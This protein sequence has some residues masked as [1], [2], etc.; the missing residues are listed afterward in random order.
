LKRRKKKIEI[1]GCDK[2]K[3]IKIRIFDKRAL[4]PIFATLLLAAIVITFGTVAYYYAS[5]VTTN[6]TNS[7]VS[8]VADSKVAISE[9]V[10]FENVVFTQNPANI[11]A[12]LINCGSLNLQLSTL[13]IYNSNQQVVGFNATLSTNSPLRNIEG[14][15]LIAGNSLS[16]GKE[17]Y[18]D[19]RLTK[20]GT[21]KVSSLSPGVYTIHLITKGGSTFDYQFV[22]P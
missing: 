2:M 8:S 9:R 17:G 7:Y 22:V 6:A 19:A 1:S 12:Y 13:F 5:N 3:K 21:D 14:D 10:G 15:A 11:R 16:I 18:F 4:S 20:T